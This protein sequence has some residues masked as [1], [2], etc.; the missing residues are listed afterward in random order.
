LEKNNPLTFESLYKVR[1]GSK[2]VDK[3]KI[4]K[5]DRNILQRLI[6]AYKAGREVDLRQILKHELLTVPISIAS[7]DTSGS[8]KSGNKPVLQ[9]EIQAGARIRHESD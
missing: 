3:R 7:I 8:L 1:V 5:A 2:A 4:I 9:N 6:L